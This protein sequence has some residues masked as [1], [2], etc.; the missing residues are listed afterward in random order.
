MSLLEELRDL[1]LLEESEMV[2]IPE[3]KNKDFIKKN[4]LSMVVWCLNPT[5][6]KVGGLVKALPPTWG[7][8]TELREEASERTK[9]SSS[10]TAAKISNM[11]WLGSRG[12]WM[13]GF[14]LW[15]SG[16]RILVQISSIE[17]L[18]G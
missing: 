2:D 5:V 15:I 6:Y 12:S 1:E 18:S 3:L 11:S 9:L 4:S 10:L 8:K 17:S 13:G 16:S 14:L 7:R